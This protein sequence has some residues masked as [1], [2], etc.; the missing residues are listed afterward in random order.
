MVQGSHAVD[1]LR[2]ERALVRE[3]QAHQR[4]GAGGGSAVQRQLG[5]AVLGAGAS[6]GGEEG[7]GRIEVRL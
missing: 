7:A 4:H 3:Q 2:V 1:V 5:A 6:A